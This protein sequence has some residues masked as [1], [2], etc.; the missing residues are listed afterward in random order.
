MKKFNDLLCLFVGCI[1]SFLIGGVAA[2][3]FACESICESE[4]TPTEEVVGE[5]QLELE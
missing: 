5:V 1:L 4:V 2:L 3:V